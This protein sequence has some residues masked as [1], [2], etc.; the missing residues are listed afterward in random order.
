MLMRSVVTRY[1]SSPQLSCFQAVGCWVGIQRK[2]LGLG[3]E[4][5][6]RIRASQHHSVFLVAT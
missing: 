2:A 4:I 3:L 1:R 6:Y 5:A